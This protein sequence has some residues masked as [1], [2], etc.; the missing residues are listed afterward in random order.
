MPNDDYE[1]FLREVGLTEAQVQASMRACGDVVPLPDGESRF[2]LALSAIH[3]LGVF[4]TV[5]IRAG[6]TLGPC[7]LGLRKTILGRYINHSPRPNV[8]FQI[9]GDGM[10]AVALE[11]IRS[12]AE[13]TVD[14]RQS[15][16][17]ALRLAGV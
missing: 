4:A 11:A 10:D 3:G 5:D 12:D 6:D 7:R 1:R 13:L 16:N 15:Y 17:L 8:A 14:Y 9:N 2:R